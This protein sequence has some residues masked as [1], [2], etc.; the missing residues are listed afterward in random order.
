[1]ADLIHGKAKSEEVNDELQKAQE[2][3][4][5]YA[6]KCGQTI[7]KVI[8]DQM[9]ELE[10]R[11]GN[12]LN[13]EFAKELA[14]RLAHRMQDIS[15]SPEM[16]SKIKTSADISQ[17]MGNF[18][19]ENSFKPGGTGAFGGMFNLGQYSGTNAHEV[20]KIVGHFCGKSF[21]PWEAVKWTKGV[22]NIG[23]G[24]AVVG[25]VLTFALQIKEDVDAQQLEN[26][27]KKSREVVRNGFNDTAKTIEMHF[28]TATGTY[29][30]K[31]FDGEF[32]SMDKQL[33]QLQEMQQTRS[34]LFENL[35][36]L[37]G[38]TRRMIK[39]LHIGNER[40]V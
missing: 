11:V 20:V 19:I 16:I 40:M 12:I 14:A 37:L 6:E 24:L 32:E 26:D 18:L 36:D 29:I 9:K 3:V 17:K 27:L 34:D 13:S 33:L 5:N 28:D 39:E 7:E 30:K 8:T 23:R 2:H 1:V 10:V 35:I 4:Q 38:E 15:S 22:A 25:T 21:K 31:T